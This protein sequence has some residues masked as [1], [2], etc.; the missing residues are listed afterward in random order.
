M[1]IS[2]L[3]HENLMKK[4][5]QEASPSLNSVLA[6]RWASDGPPT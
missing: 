2:L 4:V 6:P 5:I 1:P 3:F